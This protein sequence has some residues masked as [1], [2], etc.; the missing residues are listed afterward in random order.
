V[1]GLQRQGDEHTPAFMVGV[2]LAMD[3][4]DEAI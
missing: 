4:A 1:N 2:E 3:F